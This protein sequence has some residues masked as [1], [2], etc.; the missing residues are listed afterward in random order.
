MLFLTSPMNGLGPGS[1]P[2]LCVY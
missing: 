1:K 2:W